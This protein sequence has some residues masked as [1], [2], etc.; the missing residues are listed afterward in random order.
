MLALMNYEASADAP[1]TA[2]W[3][4]R[5]GRFHTV[6]VAALDHFALSNAEL[7]LVASGSNVLWVGSA[8]EIVSDQS[9]RARFRLALVCADR[10]F[11]L[12][13]PSDEVTRA[14]LIWDLEDATPVNGLSIA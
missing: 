5:S 4:G 14:T 8:N 1:K 12:A 13:A 7:C 9:S 2:T 11:T 6:Q 3:R 10:V